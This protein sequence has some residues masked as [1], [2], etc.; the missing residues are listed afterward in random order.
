MVAS[1]LCRLFSA[2][3]ASSYAALCMTTGLWRAGRS[4]TLLAFFGFT[5]LSSQFR[6]TGQISGSVEPARDVQLP[7]RRGRLCCGAG[8][9]NDRGNGPS[10]LSEAGS[11][12]CRTVVPSCERRLSQPGYRTCAACAIA[13]SSSAR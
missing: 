13:D 10:T 7:L 3:T 8:G 6:I 9:G 1:L 11:G 2:Y 4:A 5:M 12:I